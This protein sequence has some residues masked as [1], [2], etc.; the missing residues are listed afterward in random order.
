MSAIGETVELIASIIQ[1]DPDKLNEFLRLSTERRVLYHGVKRSDYLLG[2][3]VSGVE[4]RTPESRASHWTTGI[5]TFTNRMAPFKKDGIAT[6]DTPWFCYNAGGLVIS[7]E[8][9]LKNYGVEV[10][11]EDNCEIT[12]PSIIPRQ[13]TTIFASRDVTSCLRQY[14][15]NLFY[16]VLDHLRNYSRGKLI[17][18]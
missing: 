17:R 1:V 7:D 3:I 8:E 14:E 4:P 9:T 2:V 5:R 18:V 16:S 13:T 15:R 6:Y 10:K 12:I 11:W